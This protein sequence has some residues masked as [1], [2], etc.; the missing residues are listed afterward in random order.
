MLVSSTQ[1][2]FFLSQHRLTFI[3]NYANMLA[4]AFEPDEFYESNEVRLQVMPLH[5]IQRE[6]SIDFR[7]RI[8][9]IVM[10][11]KANALEAEMQIWGE[12]EE[13]LLEVQRQKQAMLT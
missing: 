11:S 3:H 8:L 10:G 2:N 1:P 7:T 9:D 13:T 6:Y 12:L 4:L 5:T